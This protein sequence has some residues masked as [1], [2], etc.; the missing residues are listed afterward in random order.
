LTVY[1]SI[2]CQPEQPDGTTHLGA[3]GLGLAHG[4]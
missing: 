3:E 4:L 1:R 2:L